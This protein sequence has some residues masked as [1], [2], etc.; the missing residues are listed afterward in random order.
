MRLSGENVVIHSHSIFPP[1]REICPKKEEQVE[2]HGH[3]LLTEILGRIFKF[4]FF[5][6]YSFVLVWDRDGLAQGRFLI[7][8]KEQWLFGWDKVLSS[9]RAPPR[10]G[11]I[12][13][14]C[15]LVFV[16]I[17]MTSSSDWRYQ[18]NKKTAGTCRFV[19]G[20]PSGLLGTREKHFCRR[21]WRVGLTSRRF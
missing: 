19:H 6:N 1:C 18:K 14:L 4:L 17:R 21:A 5:K 15:C 2:F 8:G 20:H 16:F 10:V 11:L 7:Q 3:I 9:A 12:H 13:V